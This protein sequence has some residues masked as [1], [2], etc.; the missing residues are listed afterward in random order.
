MKI[1]VTKHC[2]MRMKERFRLRFSQFMQNDTMLIN[3]IIG[4]VSTGVLIDDWKQVPF[5]LNQMSWK[6]GNIDV[7]KKSGVYYICSA[8]NGRMIVRTVVPNF[9]YHN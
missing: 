7:I 8:E 9:L 4:Q 5:Y 1:I 2:K 3:F 6:Y